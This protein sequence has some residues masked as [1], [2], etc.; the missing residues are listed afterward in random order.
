MGRFFIT[1][2]PGLPTG[3]ALF[4]KN[5]SLFPL[6]H[7]T[8]AASKGTWVEKVNHVG[9]Q[10]RQTKR[11]SLCDAD[12]AYVEEPKFWTSSTGMGAAQSGSL[13]KLAML[14]GYLIAQLH[15][16]KV[17]VQLVPIQKWKGGLPKAVTSRRVERFLGVNPCQWK[18]VTHHQWD[19]IGIGLHVRGI[20]I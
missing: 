18:G 13:I 16:F 15:L 12:E 1:I 19:A 11:E 5:G 8:W 6:A 9:M 7:G 3:W 20:R 4:R 17:R 10:F 2:D 14:T